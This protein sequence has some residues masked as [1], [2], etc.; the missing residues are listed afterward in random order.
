MS[1][2]PKAPSSDREPGLAHRR[3]QL[4]QQQAAMREGRSPP[5]LS[6]LGDP[7]EPDSTQEGRGLSGS[8]IGRQQDFT[9]PSGGIQVCNE[10]AREEVR[11]AVCPSG[12]PRLELPIR[13]YVRWAARKNGEALREAGAS[14]TWKGPAFTFVR[15]LK[16]HSEFE[17]LSD[18]EAAD[19]LDEILIEVI[20]SAEDRWERLLGSE[21]SMGNFGDPFDHFVECWRAVEHPHGEGPLEKALRLTSEHPLD[22]PNLRSTKWAKY[23][24]F[25]TLCYWLQVVKQPEAIYI[26]VRKFGEL[27]KA[28]PKTIT[29]YRRKAVHDGY[30]VKIAE[31]QG[32][33]KAAEFRFVPEM[34][35]TN[36]PADIED[37]WAEIE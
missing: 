13:E 27:L 22:L 2:G 23:R 9:G 4:K 35:T 12:A 36:R 29:T 18:N 17:S 6:A 11:G 33:Q 10:E 20:S 14:R 37:D 32:R 3:R 30:L 21:D 25:I 26:S 19:R 8:P 16:A 28:D 31:H 7:R 24:F 15:Y 34:V 5:P 1:R